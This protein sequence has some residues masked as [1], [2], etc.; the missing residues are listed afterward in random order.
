MSRAPIDAIVR[1]TLR[2]VDAR[3]LV[4][5]A[6]VLDG[7]TLRRGSHACDLGAVERVFVAGA[8][9]ASVSMA[10]ACLDVLGARVTGGVVV[11]KASGVTRVGPIDGVRGGHP[12]PDAASVDA[13]AR[14]RACVAQAGARDLVLALLSGGASALACAPVDG[15]SLDD[16]RATTRALMTAGADITTLNTVR[17]HLD[18]LKGG[19]LARAAAPATLLSLVLSDVPGDDLAVIASGP[20]VPDASTFADTRAALVA[21]A[22]WNTAPAGVRAHIERGLRGEVAETAK[23][24]DA[25]F[26]RA[27]TVVIGANRDAVRAAAAAARELGYDAVVD[28]APLVGEAH[29]AGRML[30]ERLRA[31]SA[32]GGRRAYVAGGETTVTLRGTGVGGRTLEL[33]LG[34]ALAID[35]VPGVALLAF[36]TDGDDGP[37]GAA[38]AFV[39]GAT[40]ARARTLD[41]DIAAALERNDTLPVFR[42]L[43]DLVV[44]GPTGTNVG[45]IVV[46]LADSSWA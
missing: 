22:A 30:G 19:G 37:T 31:L 28:D 44:T 23:R 21:H 7:D 39:T 40:G 46:L 43:G 10:E 16:L 42:A 2:A 13:G 41:L 14:L 35:G 8:G 11:T 36:A 33:A 32:R 5:A 20:T 24:D 45:D 3:A 15:V 38:G 25:C 34:A 29:E 17:K 1:A 6:L 18:T 12:L 4:R 9:K 26:A 27:D